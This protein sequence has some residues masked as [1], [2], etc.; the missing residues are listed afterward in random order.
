MRGFAAEKHVGLFRT[1]NQDEAVAAE[2]ADGTVFLAVAD[3]VGGAPGGDVASLTAMTTLVGHVTEHGPG[4]LAEAIA[5]ANARVVELQAT[6]AEWQ[7]MATTLVAAVVERDNATVANLGDSRAYAL[8]GG[9]LT[10][11]SRDDSWVSD[12]VDSGELTREQA[13]RHPYRNVVTKGLG[14][15]NGAEPAFYSLQMQPGD[16]LLLATDGLFKM[17]PD[18]EI[19][20]ILLGAEDAESARVREQERDEVQ[21]AAAFRSGNYQL[22]AK[23]LSKHATHLSPAQQRKLALALSKLR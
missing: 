19:E 14:I 11:V 21:A 13:E 7:H 5:A 22:A 17:L 10:Q 12:V 4:S 6:R 1:Q 20:R 3:G 8:L 23:L 2:L 9:Q 16:A 15:A 18:E